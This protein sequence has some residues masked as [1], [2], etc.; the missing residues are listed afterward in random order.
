MTA[1]DQPIS[2][3]CKKTCE[4]LKSECSFVINLLPMSLNASDLPTALPV[5]KDDGACDHL[6]GSTL[7]A[8]S[9]RSTSGRLVNLAE[10]TPPTVFFFYP[11]NA[12]PH[13]TIPEEWNLIPGARG[14]TPHSCGFRDLHAEFKALGFQVFGLST[15]DTEY[16]KELVQRVHLPFEILSDADF[17]LVAALRLPV[18]DYHGVRLVK[19]MA[20]IVEGGKI[21]KVFYPVFPPDKNADE[22]LTWIK[23]RR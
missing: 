7:P 23:S 8:I 6:P 10:I 16:Q 19:R 9:L 11:R 1:T 12:Q 13:E 17:K 2:I 22:V 4:R 20:W 18:F 15:Q 3:N 14:C 5:P 21:V